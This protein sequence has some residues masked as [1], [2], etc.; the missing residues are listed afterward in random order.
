M[1]LIRFPVKE[2]ETDNRGAL[3]LFFGGLLTP[4]AKLLHTLLFPYGYLAADM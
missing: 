4:N 2:N 3:G 1:Q